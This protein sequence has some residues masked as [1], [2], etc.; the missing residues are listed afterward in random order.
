MSKWGNLALAAVGC[1]SLKDSACSHPSWRPIWYLACTTLPSSAP[2]RSSEA[3]HTRTTNPCTLVGMREKYQHFLNALLFEHRPLDYLSIR[4]T[5]APARLLFSRCVERELQQHANL[6]RCRTLCP[7]PL[8]LQ[9]SNASQEH[10]CPQPTW[11][12]VARI[13]HVLGPV[14][15]LVALHISL[16]AQSR[17]LPKLYS[18]ISP[19]FGSLWEKRAL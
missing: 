13:N 15:P 10:K 18:K 16:V 5:I 1:A 19:L 9:T 12:P 7:T 2:T 8:P 11:Y 14:Q 4:R 3:M 17:V 6:H